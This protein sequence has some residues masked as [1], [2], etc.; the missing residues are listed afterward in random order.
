[1]AELG[2]M[3]PLPLSL[4]SEGVGWTVEGDEAISLLTG[5]MANFSIST[6]FEESIRRWLIG[7]AETVRISPLN[8]F[9]CLSEG[10]CFLLRCL[11]LLMVLLLLPR[12]GA[13]DVGV[14]SLLLLV[15]ELV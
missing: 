1:M 5:T 14:D 13:T 12:E 15:S 3:V 4:E 11:S 2:D 8:S 6:A 10:D 7:V 9:L